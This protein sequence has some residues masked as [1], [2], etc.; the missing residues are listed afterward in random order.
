MAGANREAERIDCVVVGAG[1]GGMLMVHLLR[2]R[3]LAVVGIEAGGDVGGVWYWNRYPGARCDVMSIDYSYSVPAHIQQEWSWSEQFA[4]QPEI[5]AYANFVAERLDL[6]R[7]YRFHTRVESARFDDGRA[8]WV[9]RTD[10]GAVIE[11][12]YC[13]MA[14]GP[15]SLPKAPEFPGGECFAGRILH[16]ARWPQEGVDLSGLRVG[17]VGTGSTGIQIVPVVARQAASLHV[18]QRTPSFTFPLRNRPIDPDHMAEIRQH[19]DGIR[20]V[21]RTTPS[22]GVRPVS[23]RP[24]FSMPREERLSLMEEAWNR[25]GM[26]FFG[27]FSD[28]LTNQAANDEV[29]DFVRGKIAG[30]VEDPD[31]AQRLM[32]RG[33]PILARRPCF[34]SGYY[35]TFNL[36]HVRLVDCLADPIVEMTEKGIRTATREVE[37]DVVILATGYDALTG[38]LL[39]FDVEGRGGLR[40]RDKWADGSRSWL[41]L[42]LA[43]FPNLFLVCGPNGPAALTNVIALNEQNALWIAGAIAHAEAT[44]AVMEPD[45]DA[46]RA[47]MDTV[48]DLA[49]RTLT[50]KA[51]TWYT[52]AN[53]A[54]KPRGLSLY[55]GGLHRFRETCDAI[56]AGGYAELVCPAN[57]RSREEAPCA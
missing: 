16:P 5:L 33:Y 49:A 7:S 29:A 54:G 26:A 22:G 15:L 44:G 11:A 3:G 42:M 21:A 53:I 18:F 45:E 25:N 50:A 35:E 13:V 4:A 39:A 36:P 55:T 2:E 8:L 17:V 46:E 20:A 51:S 6:R 23:T 56:T 57:T 9:V 37:L 31:T 12:R 10:D 47:W 1:F 30:I 19:Y 28:L 48:A 43:G 27:A 38:A 52:G 14:T 24:F 34:D 41:G 40:L 32:P